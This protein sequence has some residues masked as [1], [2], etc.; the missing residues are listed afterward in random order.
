MNV[1]GSV[2]VQKKAHE[3]YWFA[4]AHDSGWRR[5]INADGNSNSR[6]PTARVQPEFGCMSTDRTTEP[7]LSGHAACQHC[8]YE[9]PASEDSPDF[10]SSVTILQDH[11]TG[12]HACCT[13]SRR[14]LHL[15]ALQ[16]LAA[17]MALGF[18][19]R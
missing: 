15:A 6:I 10:P 9:L 17:G 3:H 8:L 12:L 2:P 14:V 16:H 7:R 1:V 5:E 19:L 4:T 18:M 11:T 13:A